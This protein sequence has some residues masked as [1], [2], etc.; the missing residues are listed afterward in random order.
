MSKYVYIFENN[1]QGLSRSNV[2]F[3]GQSVLVHD[4]AFDAVLMFEVL[5]DLLATEGT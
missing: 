1:E 4:A 5:D 3:D 2:V